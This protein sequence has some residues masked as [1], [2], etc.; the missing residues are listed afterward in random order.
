MVIPAM[1]SEASALE[2]IA[3]YATE[4]RAILQRHEHALLVLARELQQ[5]RTLEGAKIIPQ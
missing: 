2:L 5:R 3:A 4:A 1:S